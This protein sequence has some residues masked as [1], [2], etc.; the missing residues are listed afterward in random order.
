MVG[1]S[2]EH[3]IVPVRA[4]RGHL[5]C[6]GTAQLLVQFLAGTWSLASRCPSW[7]IGAGFMRK[8]RQ[9]QTA[10]MGGRLASSWDGSRHAYLRPIGLPLSRAG[11]PPGGETW[12]RS[13]QAPPRAV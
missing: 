3:R 2:G 13:T 1:D 9:L 10:V 12:P 11:S 5:R 4:E 6:E 8:T 7:G